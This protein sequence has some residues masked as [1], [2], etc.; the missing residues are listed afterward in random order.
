MTNTSAAAHTEF[1]VWMMATLGL[2]KDGKMG[3]S[4]AR[5]ERIKAAVSYAKAGKLN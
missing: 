2:I 5:S 3:A 4:R 1:K